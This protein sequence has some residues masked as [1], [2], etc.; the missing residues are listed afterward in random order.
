[1]A[2]LPVSSQHLYLPH[3]TSS[4]L[5]PPP[6]HHVWVRKSGGFIFTEKLRVYGVKWKDVISFTVCYWLVAD[7]EV[8]KSIE[9]NKAAMCKGGLPSARAW[10]GPWAQLKER[11]TWWARYIHIWSCHIIWVKDLN[12]HIKRKHTTANL[13]NTYIKRKCWI[14]KITISLIYYFA[15]VSENTV[16]SCWRPRERGIVLY[17]WWH[18]EWINLLWKTIWIFLQIWQQNYYLIHHFYSWIYIL[19]ILRH[20][21]LSCTTLFVAACF[22]V[23][24]YELTLDVH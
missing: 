18:C 19:K 1:M 8:S 15:K 2:P 5:E 12:R 4:N 6:L 13:A 24:K 14:L 20:K 3:Q 22:T 9:K 17:F 11:M 23:F 21:T 7:T 16:K 10:W